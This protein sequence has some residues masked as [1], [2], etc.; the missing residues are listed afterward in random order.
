[1]ELNKQQQEAVHSKFQHNMV[2]AGAGT[3]KT[4]TI[5]HRIFFLIKQ[6]VSPNKI[7]VLTFTRKAA[8]EI[9][10]RL[11]NELLQNTNNIFVGT[12]HQ[13]CISN[14]RKY[15]AFFDN[16]QYRIIDREEQLRM[17][18]ELKNAT[19]KMEINNSEL[20]QYISYAR[21]CNIAI[22]NYL[23]KYQ[24]FDEQTR[25][26]I[27]DIEKNYHKQKKKFNYLDFDDILFIFS[28]EIEKQ[29]S[30]KEIIWKNH[31]HFLVDEMQDTN[32][33]QWRILEAIAS[34]TF[35]FC[36]GDD[37]QSIYMFRGADFRNVQHFTK[38]LKE[39]Q[40][41]K[42]RENFRSTQ[43]ILDLANWL[44]EESELPYNKK[45]IAHRGSG[46]KPQVHSFKNEHDEARWVASEVCKNY[47]EIASYSK[48]M[49]LVRSA[50]NAKRL[51]AQFV[52]QNIPYVFIG[53]V[54]LMASAHVKDLL[55]LLQ[56]AASPKD[57]LAW[58]RYL[59][60]WPKIG[61]KTAEK[62]YQQIARLKNL[63]SIIVF[64]ENQFPK[65][66]QIAQNLAIVSQNSGD[67]YLCVESAMNQMDDFF[68]IS[69]DNWELR[70]KD[71]FLIKEM[72]KKHVTLENFLE[73]YTLEP[74]YANSGQDTR[75]K[76]TLI[77]V[78]S[79]KGAEAEICYLLKAQENIYP[80]QRSIGDLEAEEE[81][82]RVLYVAMTRAKEKLYITRS[83][84]S[85][86]SFSFDAP[87]DNKYFLTNIPKELAN[88]HRH[89]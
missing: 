32:P 19:S 65:N 1:V 11:K 53:G 12:F 63:D 29:S 42:L 68:S 89:F 35:L 45:L 74:I 41:L 77:T 62:I 52:E 23:D 50:W 3:G 75:D 34:K 17:I 22:E 71:I 79:A 83:L 40:N 20:L 36:V 33:I 31:Q 49:V 84:P 57:R 81:E 78:H 7:V 86:F 85:F 70:K 82:R 30:L 27:I 15:S 5:I 55:S 37:A 14:I 54:N 69:Y 56:L 76:V 73:T 9:I 48:Q 39:S 16:Q 61:L 64:L 21:N 2:F 10:Y 72:A 25:L 66:L 80:H 58:M 18:K 24:Y 47:Q 51:E 87:E 26:Q 60:L 4:R 88:F 38:R 6:G 13:F 43:E 44:L 8:N 28:S 46:A 59:C 67:P